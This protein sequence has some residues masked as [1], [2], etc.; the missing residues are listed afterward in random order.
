MGRLKVNCS[1]LKIEYSFIPALV[2]VSQ[3]MHT[4]DNTMSQSLQDGEKGRGAVSVSKPK[5]RC[6]YALIFYR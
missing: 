3:S 2:G 4:I 5:R 1:T 6:V